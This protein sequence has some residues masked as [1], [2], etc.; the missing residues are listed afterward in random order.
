MDYFVQPNAALCSRN[1]PLRSSRSLQHQACR[2]ASLAKGV[3]EIGNGAGPVGVLIAV[4]SIA[5]GLLDSNA[6]PISVQLVSGHHG[7]HAADSCSHLRAVRDD[8]H[9]TGG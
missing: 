9:R 2:G 1:L 5:N 4:F 7:K 8:D 6:L 3:V